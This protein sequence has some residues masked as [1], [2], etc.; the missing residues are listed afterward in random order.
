MYYWCRYALAAT[1][2]LTTVTGV[3]VA[4]DQAEGG[5][6]SRLRALDAKYG[7]RLKHS[8]AALRIRSQGVSSQAAAGDLFVNND[9]F[10]GSSNQT[11]LKVVRQ[12]NGGTI[13]VWTDDRDANLSVYGQVFDSA[14]IPL[15]ENFRLHSDPN[16]LNQLDPAALVRSDGGF[17]AAFTE[18][19]PNNDARLIV[20]RYSRLG[21]PLG[22]AVFVAAFAGDPLL[23]RKPA[24]AALAN[25]DV[26]VIFEQ[27]NFVDPNSSIYGQ[28]FLADALT[29]IGPKFEVSADLT[30][31][32]TSIIYDERE[33]AV[34]VGPNDVIWVVWTDDRDGGVRDVFV[35]RL[36][37]D[38]VAA[39]ADTTGQTIFKTGSASKINDEPVAENTLQNT[40][41]LAVSSNNRMLVVWADFRNDNWNV[42]KQ[43]YDALGAKS[44]NNV[45]VN[46]SDISPFN[47]HLAPMVSWSDSVGVVVWKDFRSG[48]AQTFAQRYDAMGEGIL[49][50]F[51]V[52]DAGTGNQSSPNASIM[53]DGSF[54]IGWTQP[55]SG[56]SSAYYRAV[57]ANDVPGPSQ[58]VAVTVISAKQIKP[59]CAVGASGDIFT[60]WEESRA[61]LPNI[62]GQ[63]LDN[64]LS[65]PQ[66]DL[67]VNG[68]PAV[69]HFLPAVAVGGTT[70]FAV[71]E[72]YRSTLE[73]S[74]SDIFLQ[75]FRLDATGYTAV[76][77]NVRVIDTVESDDVHLSSWNPDAAA[78][79]NG[80]CM[81]V[82]QDNRFESWDIFAALYSDSIDGGT[83]DPV[84]IGLNFRVDQGP[85]LTKQEEP[86]VDMNEVGNAVVIWQD[87]RDGAYDFEVWAR[88]Y[89]GGGTTSLGNEVRLMLDATHIPRQPDVAVWVDGSFAV[90]YEEHSDSNNVQIYIQRFD[91]TGAPA[92]GGLGNSILVNDDGGST[93][94]FSPRVAATSAGYVVVW[95]D[96]RAGNWD[97][98]ASLVPFSATVANVNYIVNDPESTDQTVP[99]IAALRSEP[100]PYVCWEDLR[101]AATAP[102]IFANRNAPTIAAGIGDDWTGDQGLTPREFTL[103]QNV[104]NPFNPATEIRFTLESPVHV[105]LIVFNLLGQKVRTL[106]DAPR[107]AGSHR[108]SWDGVSDAGV[109]VATGTYMYRLRWPEGE[110]SRKMTLLK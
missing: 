64:S 21:Q 13:A 95:Q 2:T 36:I 8:E 15:G 30:V 47:N 103:G 24:L 80:R 107:V 63:A 10:G 81:V 11:Q 72:D 49:T 57:S 1:L 70:G 102:D 73:D 42:F 12:P 94:H 35:Q 54:A 18:E 51:F 106:L 62:V 83:G 78:D 67:Q 39:A 109:R 89:S 87:S 37:D 17:Y 32:G 48:T 90:V 93:L 33:P 9:G 22:S 6:E 16:N 26:I 31:D 4:G 61:A 77:S 108:V 74:Y 55:E 44:Q 88:M 69:F 105:E 92:S 85:I 110:I 52:G 40:P 99:T 98:Y 38:P 71:W 7:V 79:A 96:E 50:N 75:R 76:G 25:G 84:R 56:L 100:D 59:I 65:K 19:L 29:P 46:F 27:D 3:A 82:W 43:S 97:I 28:R 91:N 41:Q 14:G 23:Q 60:M 20:Q 58:T 104:P 86:R 34:S 66:G 53:S 101:L 45:L 5:L 68:G